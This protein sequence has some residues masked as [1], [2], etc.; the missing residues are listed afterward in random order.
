MLTRSNEVFKPTRGNGWALES[1]MVRRYR[2]GSDVLFQEL[3]GEAVLLHLASGVYYSLDAVGTRIW[4]LAAA[5]NSP[6]AVAAQL[7]REYEVTAEQASQDVAALLAE[8]QRHD[9]LHGHDC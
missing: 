5:G 7:L 2:P 3:D 9:L 1:L 6:E 8:L 4:N